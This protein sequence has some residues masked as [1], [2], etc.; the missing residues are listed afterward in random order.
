MKTRDQWAAEGADLA[1]DLGRPAAPAEV[2]VNDV[3]LPPGA[4]LPSA[5][6]N[7]AA[8]RV[9]AVAKDVE[10]LDGNYGVANQ[11]CNDMF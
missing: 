7:V 6:V 8:D 5:V 10:R 9:S 2:S 3:E 11:A 4:E 1:H